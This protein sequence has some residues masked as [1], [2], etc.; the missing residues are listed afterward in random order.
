MNNT[1]ELK[2]YLKWLDI[3]IGCS[4]DYSSLFDEEEEYDLT[5]D[6]IVEIV[7]ESLQEMYEDTNDLEILKWKERLKNIYASLEV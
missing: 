6:E 3:Q 5:T 2:N 1:N 7:M 4:N